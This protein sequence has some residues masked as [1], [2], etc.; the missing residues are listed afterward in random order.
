MNQIRVVFS[1][2]VLALAVAGCGGT[3]TA[4]SSTTPIRHVVV[5][6][7]S[8]AVTPTTAQSFPSDLEHDI[9]QAH[10]PWVIDNAGVSGDTTSDGLRRYQALLTSDVGVLVLELGANDGLRGQ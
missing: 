9:E 5:L 10:L 6:G 2:L 7:D 8:L 3:A 1:T 4:P